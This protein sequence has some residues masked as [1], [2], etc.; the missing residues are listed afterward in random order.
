MSLIDRLTSS[1]PKRIL[2]LDGGG[3][4]GT[5]TLGFLK[6]IETILRERHNNPSLKLAD[7]F[8]LIGGTSTGAI[9]A[10]ALAIGMDVD[11]IRERYLDLGGKIFSSKSSINFLFYSQKFDVKHLEK[12]LCD[13]FQD[14]KLGDEDIKTGLCIVAKRA[15]TGSTWPILNHPNG[16]FYP[17][18]KLVLLRD[19]IRASSAAPTYFE[20]EKINVGFG[21][22][23]YFVDG[24]VSSA[25]NPGLLLFLVAT[26]KGFPYKWPTGEKNLMI[27]SVGTGS[28]KPRYPMEK[29]DKQFALTWG[30]RSI[31]FL[32][33]DSSQLNQLLLQYFSHSPTPVF[34]DTEIEDMKNDMLTIEPLLHYLRYNISMDTRNKEDI[35]KYLGKPTS[36]K[37]I[38]S[39]QQMDKADNRFD[40][41]LIGTNAAKEKVLEAH[42]PAIFDRQEYKK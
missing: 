3:I 8:D 41:D 36:E 20:P 34:I 11:T 22:F 40:M 12:S 24:G 21:E 2:S 6:R 14:I 37:Q 18:N 30:V 16:K 1:G 25:N 9:I 17:Q 35:E 26:L 28:T 42:F 32:M 15:D 31:E 13:I 7:Y 39:L 38:K 23:G 29:I 33:H 4:R 19:A 27:V 10:G 5:L